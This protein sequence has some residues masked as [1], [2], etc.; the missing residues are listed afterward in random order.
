M[1]LRSVILLNQRSEICN[2]P[3]VTDTSKY[4]SI[5]QRMII[6]WFIYKRKA[7]SLFMKQLAMLSYLK[8]YKNS[9][10]VGNLFIRLTIVFEFT[11]RTGVM[12]GLA[13]T[14]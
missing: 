9:C 3:P 8:A 12:L 7:M 13:F 2:F 5:N 4:L 14:V 11:Y 1:L 6:Y 10:A